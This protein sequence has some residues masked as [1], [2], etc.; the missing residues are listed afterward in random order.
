MYIRTQNELR[1]QVRVRAEGTA[2]VLKTVTTFLVLVRAP[3]DWALVAFALGQ[4]A[5]GLTMLLSFTVA[6]RDNL[7]FRPKRVTVTK[8]DRYV[9]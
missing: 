2:V 4:T 3:E 8:A 1:F 7:D 5:Y 9:P 6:C